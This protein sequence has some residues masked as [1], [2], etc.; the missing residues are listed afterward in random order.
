MNWDSLRRCLLIFAITIAPSIPAEGAKPASALSG[1]V[2]FAASLL[3]AQRAGQL[4]LRLI[5]KDAASGTV[6]VTNKT[7]Q[8]LTV[9]LPEAFAGVPILG[10]R[11]ARGGGAN[12]GNLN[13]AAGGGNQSLGGGFGGG[14]LNGGGGIGG[15]G[16]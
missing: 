15:A 9:R 11:G 5:P 8:P 12:A 6:I 1:E 2:E 16:G 4:D 13:G 10:Q 7:K 14:G 3:D